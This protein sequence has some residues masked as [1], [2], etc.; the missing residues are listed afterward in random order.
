M[1]SP[2]NANQENVGASEA[3]DEDEIRFD[4]IENGNNVDNIVDMG[5]GCR[6]SFDAKNDYDREHKM[7]VSRITNE[8]EEEIELF[9]GQIFEDMNT[10]HDGLVS[11]SEWLKYADGDEDID[12]FVA[13]FMLQTTS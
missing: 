3:I 7:Y 8:I 5:G 12:E 11:L 6:M 9:V 2:E 13:H 4:I 1:K 10:K